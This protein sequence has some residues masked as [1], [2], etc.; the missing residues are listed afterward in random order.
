MTPE[1]RQDKVRLLRRQED[2]KK[3]LP[4]LLNDLSVIAN[5]DFSENDV[6]T[7][8]HP[9]FVLRSYFWPWWTGILSEIPYVS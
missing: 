3:R 6:L 2:R 8:E 7:I 4:S 5:R 1:Q 9:R